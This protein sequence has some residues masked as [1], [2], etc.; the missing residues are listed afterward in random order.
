MAHMIW[1][2][3]IWQNSYAHQIQFG[4]ARRL[5]QN[6]IGDVAYVAYGEIVYAIFS[7]A[8]ESLVIAYGKIPY[9]NI[10]YYIMHIIYNILHI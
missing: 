1:K 9:G 4:D 8:M 10:A 2:N 7:C 5:F 3:T 6:I